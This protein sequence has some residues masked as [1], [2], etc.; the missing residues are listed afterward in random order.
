MRQLPV[1]FTG[2][3]D[4]WRRLARRDLLLNLLFTGFYTP[5]AKRRAGDWFLR[6]TQLHGTPIEVLPVAKSRWPVVVIVVLFIALRIATDIGFGPPLPVVIVTGLVL[7]PY[8]WRTTAARRVDG[9]RWRGVQLRFV[10][11]W[12]EVYRASWPL[13][14]IG[15]PW[16]VIAPRVAES[17]QGGEL[18]FPPGLVAA[19][20]VL[21]AAALPLLVRLSFNYRRL[22]VTRTVAGPHSI[23]WDALFGRYLAIWATSA[24]AFAVSVFPVVLGLRYAIFGTAAMPEGATGWQAIAVPL[25][26]ALLAVVLSAPA[27]SWHE[28]RMFSLLWNNVR[29]GEAARFSCTLDERA[30]VRE[31]GRFD[32]YRVK[33]ASVSLW[34]ADAEKM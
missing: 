7:L 32:K 23:E 17:S 27:R 28:A 15:M 18:H 24:L 6:H 26:G 2:D 29:V 8:L 16:A 3:R 31:R 33:A 10:A 4:E 12:A 1:T 5:I 22:L 30:F 14:A 20:V 21:V 25:A 9:L 19:L 34:V 13:F 11:G